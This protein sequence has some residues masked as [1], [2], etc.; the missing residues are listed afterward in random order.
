MTN[1][2][3]SQTIKSKITFYDNG[4]IILWA[5]WED[6]ENIKQTDPNASGLSINIGQD[7]GITELLN[8]LRSIG[9]L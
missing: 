1:S 2:W 4:D 3:T 5:S 8:G 7:T 9:K 6:I